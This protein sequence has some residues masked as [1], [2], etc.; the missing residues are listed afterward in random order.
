MKVACIG[1]GPSDLFFSLLLKKSNPNFKV[2]VFDRDPRG[3]TFG[4]GVVLSYE[5]LLKVRNADPVVFE[6]DKSAIG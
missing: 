1:G 5:A 6:H 2:T 4:W 3:N